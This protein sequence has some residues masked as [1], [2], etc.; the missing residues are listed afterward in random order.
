MDRGHRLGILLFRWTVARSS[1]KESFPDVGWTCIQGQLLRTLDR[2]ACLAGRSVL[3]ARSRHRR[4]QPPSW[5]G[6]GSLRSHQ[7]RSASCACVCV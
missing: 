3:L 2:L 6:V 7:A 5:W 1:V 4:F